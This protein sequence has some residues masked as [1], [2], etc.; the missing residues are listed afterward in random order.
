MGGVDL[1]KGDDINQLART[2][3]MC[4]F[5]ILIKYIGVIV[6][7]I[8]YADHPAEDDKGGEKAPVVE[9]ANATA[10]VKRKARAL[11]NDLENIPLH[12]VVYWATFLMIN[13]TLTESDSAFTV[14]ALNGFMI[15]YT[16]FRYL[17]TLCYVFALQ[18]F[19]TICF[20][21]ALLCT[22][23]TSVVLVYAAFQLDAQDP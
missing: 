14:A 15:M 16:I 19:R 1:A 7:S 4:T 18:P 11:A 17:Y 5:A 10:I 23:A 8:N 20:A 6:Y 3:G 2:M 21:L 12:M 13:M 9:D 22:V